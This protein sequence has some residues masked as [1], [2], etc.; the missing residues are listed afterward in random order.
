MPLVTWNESSKNVAYIYFF[1][2]SHVDPNCWALGLSEIYLGSENGG[3]FMKIVVSVSAN[4]IYYFYS[5]F[6]LYIVTRM[7]LED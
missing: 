3:V 6:I 2:Y 4:L 1:K 7:F 5:F